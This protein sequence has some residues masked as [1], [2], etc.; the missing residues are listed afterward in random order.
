LTFSPNKDKEL[1]E[2]YGMFLGIN[3]IMN[4]V[5]KKWLKDGK[6]HAYQSSMARLW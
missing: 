3:C 4:K 6:W 5:K 2:N 1:D